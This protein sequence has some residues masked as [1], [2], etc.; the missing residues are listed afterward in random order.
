MKCPHC[1]GELAFPRD[2]AFYGKKGLCVQ[3]GLEA[4][5]DVLEALAASLAPAGVL[6]AAGKLLADAG[7]TTGGLN[8]GFALRREATGERFEGETLAAAYT[9]LMEGRD[10]SG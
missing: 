9:K 6:E 4:P 7:A 5:R 3:C 8:G 2:Q 10:G 1:G